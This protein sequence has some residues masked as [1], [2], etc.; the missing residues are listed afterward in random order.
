MATLNDMLVYLRKREGLSQQ[1]L[2]NSTG[3]KRSAIGMYET[4]KRQPDLETLEIFADFYN[5]DMNTLTG[6][7]S[8]NPA[9]SNIM[10]MPSTRKVPRLGRIACGSPILA[11]QNIETYDAVPDY[12]TCD[13]T[14]VCKGDSM[15]N[16]RIFDGDIVCIRQQPEVENGEIA[17]VLIDTEE[18]TLKRVKLFEDHISL[19]P[20]NPMYKP[21]VFWNEDMNRIRIIGKATHFISNV[22]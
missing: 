18:A 13:F 3:L 17:A 8:L 19:E 4:G 15:I 6:H 9:L 12:V 16:A 10:P 2:A 7:I 20:E 14:L 11:D 1:E 5:V 21:L 22:R